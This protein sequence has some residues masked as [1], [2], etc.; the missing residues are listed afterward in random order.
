MVG[1]GPAQG[2]AVTRVGLTPG[3]SPDL[4]TLENLWKL[5]QQELGSVEPC[6]SVQQLAERLKSVWASVPW[7]TLKRLVS[8]MPK[9]VSKCA[10]LRGEHIGMQFKNNGD[11]KNNGDHLP[12]PIEGAGTGPMLSGHGVIRNME[13]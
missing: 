9:R 4:N 13:L 2:K 8:V 6:T 7:A 3:S 11:L 10:A 5:I 12:N 1:S